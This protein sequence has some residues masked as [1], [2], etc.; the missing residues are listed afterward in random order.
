M[1]IKGYNKFINEKNNH[2]E[3]IL[4]LDGIN[5]NQSDETMFLDIFNI[6]LSK[7]DES[8]KQEIE[9]YLSKTQLLKEGFFDK[10]KERFPKASQVSKSLS[11]K[12]SKVLKKILDASKNAVSFVKN[13]KNGIKDFFSKMLEKG[14]DFISNHIKNGEIKKK[15]DE[16]ND[17]QKLGLITDIKTGKEV[18]SWYN[19]TFLSKLFK[20]VDK[21]MVNFMESDQEPISESKIYESGNVISTLVH[22][23]EEIPPFSWL[24]KVAKAGEAGTNK[25]FQILSNITHKMGGPSFELPV[26]ALLLG[27][28]FEQFI[29]GQ[30]GHWLIELVGSGT[31]FGLAIKGIKM[32]ALVIACIVSI[33]AI[34][35]GKLMG[36]NKKGSN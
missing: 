12:G 2:N 22:K 10:L 24:E 23:L 35:G 16:L 36:S 19:E 11:D 29:K 14:K 30:T 6:H 18:T 5:V 33:D 9:L 1:Y 27:V 26:I 4:S 13:I 28:V 15:I 32:I 17:K 3:N 7:L 20:S 25:L 31:P 34:I 8:L 21:N